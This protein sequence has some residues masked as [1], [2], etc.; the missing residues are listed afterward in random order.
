MCMHDVRYR[1]VTEFSR[2]DNIDSPP[3]NTIYH[4]Q[5]RETFRELKTGSV[6]TSTVCAS[7][8]F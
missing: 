7:S 5:L 3:N 6:I 8:Q 2:G 1:P 4:L